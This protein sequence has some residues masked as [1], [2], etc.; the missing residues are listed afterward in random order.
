VTAYTPKF[1]FSVPKTEIPGSAKTTIAIVTFN[2]SAKTFNSFNSRFV[3]DLQNVLVA[4]GYNVKGP[5]TSVDDLTYS[6]KKG[7]DF[8]LLYSLSG[9]STFDNVQS[10]GGGSTS[11][12]PNSE[13]ARIW[14]GTYGSLLGV[15]IKNMNGNADYFHGNLLTS[16]KIN[17]ELDESMSGEKLWR[18]TVDI[19]A[20]PEPFDTASPHA[21]ANGETPAIAMSKTTYWDLGMTNALNEALDSIYTNAFNT[22][23]KQLDP[24]ELR[25]LKKQA[26][27]IKSK[28]RF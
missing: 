18:K 10:T 17:I 26:D 13:E 16:A 3:Q 5:F 22:I 19:S 23:W 1:Q 9:T 28:K 7:S 15:P 4:R 25:D 24:E 27:E 8:I 14:D 12:L 11:D 21:M 20:N 6:D 2:K